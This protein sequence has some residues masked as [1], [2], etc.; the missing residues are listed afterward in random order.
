MKVFNDHPE[1][2]GL[3]G[4]CQFLQFIPLPDEVMDFF[5]PVAGQIIQLLKG[6]AFLPTLSSGGQVVYKLPSQVAVCKDAVIRKVISQEE[7]E[8]HLLLSYLHPGLSPAPP[9]SLLSHLGVRHLRG[10]D[11]T[12]VTTAMAKELMKEETIH[13]DAGLRQLARLLVCNFRAVEH[14]YGDGDSIL[15][16]LRTLPI[17]PLADGRVVAL[18]GDGVF[19]PLE[20]SKEKK[21]TTEAQ[22]GNYYSAN[23]AW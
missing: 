23:C 14:G 10:S 18:D 21:K 6:K 7:L 4:L 12:T 20:Q 11:V 8:K 17:I 1:F 13:T 2:T 22:T 5:K 3:R 15:Q 19:F 16:T 9:A